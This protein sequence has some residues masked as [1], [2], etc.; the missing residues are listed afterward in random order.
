[1][2]HLSAAQRDN[3]ISIASLAL[4]CQNIASQTGI[5]KST[6][7]RVLKEVQPDKE[8]H[9]GGC[10]SKLSPTNKCAIVQRIL[11]GKASNAVQA[12]HFINT[13]ISTPVSSQTARNTVK[14]ASL[15]AVVKKKNPLLSVLDTA[16][17]TA[18]L[19]P[20]KGHSI[21]IGA[22]LEHLLCRIP[23]DVINVKG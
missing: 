20:L 23:F 18:G 13:I 1:M 21:H 16:I 12:T 9:Y 17:D 15:K 2:K 14:E 3:I 4:S 10:P 5:G 8:N 7:A 22:M 6:V 11:T 19:T